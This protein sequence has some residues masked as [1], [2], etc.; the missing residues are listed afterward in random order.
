ME[1]K[2]DK[3]THVVYKFQLIRNQDGMEIKTFEKR[4][5]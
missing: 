4:F 1:I 2:Q 3:K 5:K